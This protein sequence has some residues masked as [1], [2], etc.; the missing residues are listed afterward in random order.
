MNYGDILKDSQGRAAEGLLATKIIDLMDKLRLQATELSA[1]RWVWEL[2]QNA[3]DCAYDDGFVTVSV[4]LTNSETNPSLAF[5]HNGRPFSSDNITSLIHQVSSKKRT[6]N[7]VTKRKPTG[8]FGT[9]FLS[10]HLLSEIVEVQGV[11]KEDGLPYKE[12]KIELDR[13]ATNPDDVLESVNASI[14]AITRLLNSDEQLLNFDKNQ[15]NTVFTYRLQNKKISI[16]EKGIADLHI[17]LPYTLAFTPEIAQVDL[18]HHQYWYAVKS[19]S[20]LETGGLELVV[21]Q[22]EDTLAGLVI[23]RRII[24]CNGE[25][26][27]IAIE[28]IQNEDIISIQPFDEDTP[29]LFCDFPLIGSEN[30]PF[31]VIIN[32]PSFNINE[33]RNGVW[34]TDIDDNR[35]IQNEALMAEALELL[36]TLMK[37]A[38]ANNWYGMFELAKINPAEKSDWLSKEWFDEHVLQPVRELILYQPIIDTSIGRI[39]ILNEDNHVQVMFPNGES[40]EI[41]EKIWH[42]G[43]PMYTFPIIEQAEAWADVLWKSSLR[44]TLPVLAKR[45]ESLENIES[46]QAELGH[47]FD[48]FTWLNDFYTV[49]NLDEAFIKDV[50]SDGYAIIPNQKEQFKNRSELLIGTDVQE[51]I[52]DALEILSVEIRDTLIH[53]RAYTGSTMAYTVKREQKVIEEINTLLSS[54]NVALELKHKVCDHVVSLFPDDDKDNVHRTKMY[55]LSKTVYFNIEERKYIKNNPDLW[56]EADKIQLR[57]LVSTVSIEKTVSQFSN[58]NN[59][60]ETQGLKFI[61]ELVAFLIKNDMEGQLNLTTKPILPNQH[62]EFMVKDEIS[63][64]DGEI[65]EALKTIAENLG[66]DVRTVLLDKR[67]FLELPANR[68]MTSA[69]VSSEISIRVMS[70]ASINPRPEDIKEAFKLLLLYFIDYPEVSKNLFTELYHLKHKLYDDQEIASNLKQAEDVKQL[71]EDMNIGSISE[72]RDLLARGRS[73]TDDTI[74]E[75]EP[76]TTEILA[77]WGISSMEEYTVLAGA[78][79][80]SSIFKHYSIPTPEMLHIAHSL[81]D[82]AKNNI[83]NYLED[84]PDY[85]LTE[86]DLIAPTVLAGITKLKLPI[87][88]VFRPSDNGEVLFYYPSEKA[89]LDLDNAELWVED[90]FIEPFHLTLGKILQSTGI[91][92]IPIHGNN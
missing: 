25:N 37:F 45:I 89:T 31:P 40:R 46:L 17:S 7:V 28:I 80:S 27:S 82:R 16:A 42:L 75:Q 55:K 14:K 68:T 1:R 88:V 73:A 5:S 26:T 70:A 38:S 85:D 90:G 50:I 41:T 4:V 92:R 44:V 59:V 86:M 78:D 34:L 8:K 3:K 33:P 30:F 52:K 23:E 47:T 84:H 9:G 66:H 91:N 65:E 72:M 18:D 20:P 71:M 22:E 67:I 61:D 6:K 49:M 64:D 2:L 29:R 19:R 15:L 69:D 12:F 36:E 10:T 57:R 35:V 53:P 83:I 62:G 51:E 60:E 11:V 24:V 74:Q 48:A 21:I 56:K 87:H 54:S 43:Q 79:V 77:S 76:I 58:V 32:S 13:R 63:L 81:I 39:S